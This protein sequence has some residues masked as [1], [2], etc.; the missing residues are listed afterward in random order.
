M[1]A[2][3]LVPYVVWLLFV[4]ALSAIVFGCIG[5]W[6]GRMP[7][8]M[9]DVVA[10]SMEHRLLADLWA[11]TASYA[12]GFLGGLILCVLIWDRRGVM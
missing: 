12:S 8:G 1:N 6:W 7:E 5:Y 11:H 9:S 2:G 4:M 3:Q 10:A